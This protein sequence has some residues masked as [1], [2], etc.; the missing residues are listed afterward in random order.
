M[1]IKAKRDTSDDFRCQQGRCK[2]P[3]DLTLEGKRYCRGHFHE[4]SD[5][6]QALGP[7][8]HHLSC[9][10]DKSDGEKRGRRG[11]PRYTPAH[12][13]RGGPF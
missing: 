2:K 10:S 11:K 3:A 7:Q 6:R 12:Q 9:R 8:G 4:E 5:R 1:T 13:K